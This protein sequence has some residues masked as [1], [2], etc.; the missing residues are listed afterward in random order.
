MVVIKFSVSGCGH[1]FSKF[2]QIALIAVRLIR[3]NQLEFRYR[4]SRFFFSFRRTSRIRA[5]KV[6]RPVR[7]DG[8]SRRA[9]MAQQGTREEQRSQSDVGGERSDDATSRQRTFL[10]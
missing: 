5:A 6:R 8:V 7:A 9:K 3:Q 1:F 10:R 2:S 4:C